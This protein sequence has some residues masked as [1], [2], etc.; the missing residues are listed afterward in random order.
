MNWRE[1]NES[2]KLYYTLLIYKKSVNEVKNKLKDDL[3]KVNKRMKDAY[4]KKIINDRLFQIV[5]LLDTQFKDNNIL[6]CIILSGR[7]L[8]YFTLSNN[9]LELCKKWNLNNFY[10]ESSDKFRIKYLKN[11]F[12]EDK[13]KLIFEINSNQISLIE[14]DK[15][16]SRLLDKIKVENYNEVLDLIEKNN[17][18][19]VHGIGSTIKKIKDLSN[20]YYKK[21]SSEEINNI[22]NKMEV[23]NSQ[24][25]LKKE[26]LN[27]LSNPAFDDKFLFGKKEV[28]NGILDYMVKKLYITPSLMRQ[29]RKNISK[30][31][32]NFEILEVDSLESGDIGDHFVK[33]YDGIIALKYY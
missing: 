26:V 3:D 7:N 20:I 1:N 25:I 2:G 18:K 6:N 12:S 13:V 5:N 14:L 31:Y 22:I 30:D 29:L 10:I 28:P 8:N 4:K 23:I 24:N 9:E 16:K 17:P 15:V 32:I 11:L 21:L 19:I 33:D 27:Q